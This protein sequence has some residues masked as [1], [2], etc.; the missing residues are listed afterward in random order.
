MG[1]K[2]LLHLIFHPSELFFYYLEVDLEALDPAQ[3]IGRYYEN[4]Y[5]LHSCPKL[6]STY[7]QRSIETFYSS[8][9]IE[10]IR[11]DI[12]NEKPKHR[13]SFLSFSFFF[14]SKKIRK[15]PKIYYV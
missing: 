8:I 2:R 15:R 11:N 10:N 1:D 14:L 13:E 3:F 7:K 6:E 4:K 12:K 5:S 9:S